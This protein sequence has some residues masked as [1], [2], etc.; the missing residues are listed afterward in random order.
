MPEDIV[1]EEKEKRTDQGSF[2]DR[3][4]SSKESLGKGRD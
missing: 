2:P 3:M 4:I 1:L